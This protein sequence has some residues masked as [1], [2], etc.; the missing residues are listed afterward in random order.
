MKQT[1][2]LLGILVAAT[3]PAQVV[4]K[5]YEQS[6]VGSLWSDSALNPFKDRTAQREGDLITILIS[7]SSAADF[8]SNFTLNKT[9]NNQVSVDLFAKV[10]NRILTP[11]TTSGTSNNAGGG[12]NGQTGKMTARLTAVVKKVMPNGQLLI[13]ASRTVAINRDVQVFK[14]SGV[15]RRDDVRSDNTV[16]SER[17]GEADIQMTG[18]GAIYDRTRRGLLTRILDWLF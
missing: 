8:K 7:E 3:V 1:M 4:D 6:S 2:F 16:L 5:N 18:K 14:L 11:S 15:V 17:I 13:E 9:D 12:T 10:L